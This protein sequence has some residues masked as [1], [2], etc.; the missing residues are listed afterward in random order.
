MPSRPQCP[1][2][3]AGVGE[4]MVRE[5]GLPAW[6][7]TQ[8]GW[9]MGR[10]LLPRRLQIPPLQ[11]LLTRRAGQAPG[12]RG[13]AV[14]G[15]TQPQKPTLKGSVPIG[16]PPGVLG[17]GWAPPLGGH[18]LACPPLQQLSSWHVLASHS[19]P[20]C[21]LQRQSVS[22]PLSVPRG[23]LSSCSGGSAASGG[24]EGPFTWRHQEG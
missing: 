8:G 16:R 17:R 23:L 10:K 18:H 9:C 4:A 11:P 6:K 15:L 13:P 7:K 14:C 1:V 5:Q 12:S 21:V 2:Q 3:T 20:G 19:Q 24:S 22:T